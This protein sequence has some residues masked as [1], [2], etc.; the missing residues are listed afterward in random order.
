MSEKDRFWDD[1][2]EEAERIV[3]CGKCP[4]R[5]ECTNSKYASECGTFLRKKFER[6]MNGERK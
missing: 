4:Y 1:F 5:K 6:Y 2:W 3:R